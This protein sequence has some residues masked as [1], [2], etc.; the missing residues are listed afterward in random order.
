MI[1][2]ILSAQIPAADPSYRLVTGILRPHQ[3]PRRHLFDWLVARHGAQQSSLGKANHSCIFIG[4]IIT[5]DSHSV[6][7]RI[8]PRI[9]IEINFSNLITIIIAT[10][11][12]V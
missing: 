9:Q 8:D 7:L 3:I 10:D 11:D 1:F 5:F 6:T 4:Q 12:T 2:Q